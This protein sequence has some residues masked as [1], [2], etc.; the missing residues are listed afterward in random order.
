MPNFA[1]GLF[2]QSSPPW[3]GRDVAGGVGCGG[4]ALIKMFHAQELVGCTVSCVTAFGP[5]PALRLSHLA[6]L[7]VTIDSYFIE[8]KDIKDHK[9]PFDDT[10]SNLW[11]VGV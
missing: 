3:T 11:F 4:G 7:V 5:R 2:F 6:S 8:A 9:T 10:R 1:P